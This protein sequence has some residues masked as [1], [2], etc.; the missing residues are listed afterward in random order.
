MCVCV[1]Q[2]PPVARPLCRASL[3]VCVCVCVCVWQPRRIS[4]ISLAERVAYERC[5][6][7]G[8]TV[9]YH[10]RLESA[11]SAS[12][13][14]LFCTTG[15]LLRQLTSHPLLPGVTTVILDEVHERDM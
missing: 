11:E 6:T 5:E 10:I 2:R 3:I 7:V 9:G 14:L 15:V 8:G 4:A 12:T 1:F 13:R